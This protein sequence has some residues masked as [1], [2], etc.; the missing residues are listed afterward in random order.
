MAF[1]EEQSNNYAVCNTGLAQPILRGR[2]RRPRSGRDR[3]NFGRKN[4]AMH[5][6]SLGCDDFNKIPRIQNEWE[7]RTSLH[8]A[9]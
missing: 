8:G 5:Y 6:T 9:K 7:K 4:S 1:A 2:G 3:K